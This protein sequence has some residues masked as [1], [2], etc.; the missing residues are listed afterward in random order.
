MAS[1]ALIVRGA[2]INALAFGGSNYLFSQLQGSKVDKEGKR[3]DLAIKRLTAAQQE[4][5]RRRTQHL[6]FINEQLRQQNHSVQT[7]QDV[8][9]AMREYSLVTD[10]KLDPLGP[11]PMLSDFYTPSDDQKDC[12]IAF[13]IAVMAVVR[14]VTY[15]LAH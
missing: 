10:S 2:V 5:S 15:K 7:F 8:D 9:Q 6:D 3:H 11:E 13:V 12:E 1:I 14:L 4:W